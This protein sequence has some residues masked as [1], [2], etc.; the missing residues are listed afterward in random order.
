MLTK[1]ELIELLR[2]LAGVRVGVLG[3][4]CLDAYWTMDYSVAEPSIETGLTTRPVRS[5]RYELG[6]A[7]TIVN[8]LLA[9]GVGRVEVFGVV[10]DDPFGREMLRIMDVK[11]VQRGGILIQPE[12]WDT[13]VYLKP[14]RDGN[15]ESRLD[16]GGFNRLRDRVGEALLEQLGRALTGLDAVI[17]NGQFPQGIHTG[18]VQKRLNALMQAQ[19]DKI[20]VVD[21]RHS[22]DV[23]ANCV[24]KLNDF[25]AARLCGG[26][27]STGDVITL[28]ETRATAGKLFARWQKPVF[29]TRGAR[30]CLV[31]TAAGEHLVPG[32]HITN[33]IDPVGAGDSLLAGLTAALA[34]EYP[35]CAAAEFGNF[36][37][38]VTVQKL[39]E[40]GTASPAEILAIGTEPDYV[41]APE[42]ADDPR[43]A[44][45]WQG[46][47]IEIVTPLPAPL[48]V[49]H[50]VFD[51]D[52]TI[53]TVRQGW[54]QVMELVMIKAILG[55][56]Y[57][58]ADETLYAR[59]VKRVRQLI[60]STTGNQTITQ[61][62]GLIRLVHEFHVVPENDVLDEA[63]YKVAYLESLAGLIRE[64]LEKLRSHELDVNDLTI[65]NA[66]A[67][68]RGLRAA[69]VKLYLASGTDEKD[70][71]GEMEALGL[72]DLFEGRIFGGSGDTTKDVKRDVLDR[73]LD[74][75][76]ATNM[77]R[78]ASF[79]DGPVEI[80]ETHKRGGLTVGL[81]TDEVRRYGLSPMKRSRLIRAGAQIVVPDF[82]QMDALLR[83][84][85][86]G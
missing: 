74:D 25:E 49:T 48:R 55:S 8:N 73:I 12:Q 32:L 2:A 39:F 71:V 34:A 78:L 3:D 29:I 60:E 16:I 27:F 69:G 38:G 47:E 14:I 65:K 45:Y 53:S 50:A 6:G 36:V 44:V 10:G 54:E 80:R 28:E 63:R 26:Q 41:H 46:T 76:G 72:A 15:E 42:L 67:F 56:R 64:R 9:I 86:V 17:V 52:G 57:A 5:Q 79:G 35:A 22:S 31:K 37:A 4:F 19:A 43:K 75:I 61:M 85:G 11:G 7:G 70:L 33:L 83:L 20:F 62:Q 1:N 40:T 18:T 82:S 30:G 24:H 81:A 51:Y 68:L 58:S 66:P 13:P 23:Y 21:V 77:C 84:L 59:V